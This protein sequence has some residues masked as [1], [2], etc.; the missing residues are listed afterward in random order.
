MSYEFH[1]CPNCGS[2]NRREVRECS[3]GHLYCD[4]C[5]AM[6]QAPHKSWNKVVPACAIC[7]ER[8]YQRR[9]VIKTESDRRKEERER[10]RP[11]PGDMPPI[12]KRRTSPT[13]RQSP[14][15]TKPRTTNNTTKQEP[16]SERSIGCIE[17]IFRAIIVIVMLYIFLSAFG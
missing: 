5:M 7:G 14:P 12:S 13:R 17:M 3:R 2:K 4:G 10:N 11:H 15:V 8:T 16:D 9:G 6:I 1:S